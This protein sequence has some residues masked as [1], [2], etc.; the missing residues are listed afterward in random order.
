MAIVDVRKTLN[1]PID[2]VFELLTDHANYDK[3]PGVQTSRLTR[4][5]TTERNGLGAQREIGIQGA[6]LWEDVVGFDRPN[7]FEYRIVKARP[8][9]IKHIMGRVRLEAQGDQTA[10]QWTSEFQVR[11][12][13]LSYFLEPKLQA[14]FTHAFGKMLDEIEAR[15]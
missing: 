6:M 7:L 4:E 5:G 2:A 10:V 15:C 12:P 9:A 11:I 13:I 1:A 8:P 3:F 14:N